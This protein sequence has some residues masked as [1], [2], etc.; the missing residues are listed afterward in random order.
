R[1]FKLGD[2]YSLLFESGPADDSSRVIT[3]KK[4]SLFEYKKRFRA[5]WIGSKIY[6][7]ND[8]MNFFLGNLGMEMS[9]ITRDY[10]IVK[11]RSIVKDQRKLFLDENDLDQK[12]QTMSG[13]CVCNSE[14]RRFFL[15]RNE[16]Q[17][18]WKIEKGGKLRVTI[19]L[20]YLLI[21]IADCFG[22]D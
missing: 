22:F 14:T 11:N 6:F 20:F 5:T 12:F 15:L 19:D 4:D 9:K 1:G 17:F 7:G 13:S 21:R 16:L 8:F 3:G 2:S 18:Q 10:E